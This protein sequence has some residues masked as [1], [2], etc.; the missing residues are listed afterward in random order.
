[1]RVAFDVTREDL[2]AFLVESAQRTRSFKTRVWPG[3]GLGAFFGMVGILAVR[4]KEPLVSLAILV[5]IA[6]V[7]A[8]AWFLDWHR[9]VAS[10]SRAVADRGTLNNELGPHVIELLPEGILE[11]G[12]AGETLRKWSVIEGTT[13]TPT[14]LFI[15]VTNAGPVIVI[16]RKAFATAQHEAEF[17]A[18]VKKKGG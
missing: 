9:R 17:E 3:I 4:P 18:G 6:G 10:A 16:P 13:R 11:T 12:N 5:T 8:V 1:V 2:I 7:F 15:D 14:H